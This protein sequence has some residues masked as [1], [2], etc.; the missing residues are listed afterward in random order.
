V[1]SDVRVRPPPS[2]RKESEPVREPG[3]AANECALS[4][5]GFEC[6][7]LRTWKMKPAGCWP[8]A[9][10]RVGR[11][12]ARGIKTS[13]FRQ[14]KRTR[15]VRAPVRSGLGARALGIRASAFRRED[16]AARR[17]A[18]GLNPAGRESA[19]VRV[20]RLPLATTQPVDGAC[21]INRY[22][23]VR[24]RGGQ[25]AGSQAGEG[26]CLIS[27]RHAGSSPARPTIPPWR[28]G[29]RSGL[30]I[31]GSPV[32]IGPGG[33][34]VAGVTEARLPSKETTGGSN[35]S[36]R[37]ASWSNG[38]IAGSQPAGRGSTPREATQHSKAPWSMGR[39][40]ALQAG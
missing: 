31:Q 4:G 34:R 39:T 37:T 35:P 5:V 40:L 11:V 2:V 18:T 38:R 26:A 19:G 6:S 3:L 17:A 36:R 13:V 28:S 20:L 1:S 10:N 14:G 21:P 30:L 27:R 23:A 8:P 15:P 32:R 25:L 22:R 24:L 29:Q 9:G 16:E 12:T 33:L 7:A